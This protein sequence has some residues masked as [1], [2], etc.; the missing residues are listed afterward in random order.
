[1]RGEDFAEEKEKLP[2]YEVNKKNG[3]SVEGVK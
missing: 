1:M 3:S 2:V